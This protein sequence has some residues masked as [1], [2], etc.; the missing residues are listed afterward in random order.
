M[1]WRFTT[2]RSVRKCSA[3]IPYERFERATSFALVN[4]VTL[5]LNARINSARIE[6]ASAHRWSST[7]PLAG[8]GF[9][10]RV[11]TCERGLT[12]RAS[13]ARANLCER[14]T[15]RTRRL[16]RDPV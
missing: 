12:G 8:Q 16:R 2:S 15:V 5:I 6:C 7:L 3:T 4:P 1:Y 11:R 9:G 10:R 14:A 13:L